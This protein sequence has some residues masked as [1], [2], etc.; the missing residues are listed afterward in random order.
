[1]AYLCSDGARGGSFLRWGRWAGFGWLRYQYQRI[2]SRRHYH[3]LGLDPDLTGLIPDGNSNPGASLVPSLAFIAVGELVASASNAYVG[4]VGPS[5]FGSGGGANASSGSGD[6]IAI[7]GG[8]NGAGDLVV[9]AGHTSGTSVS[10]SDTYTNQTFASLKP[11]P[12]HLYLYVRERMARLIQLAV[13][14]GAVPEP[15]T[16]ILLSLGAGGFAGCRS[17]EGEGFLTMPLRSRCRRV[18]GGGEGAGFSWLLP[19]TLL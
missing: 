2:W 7:Q 3:G 12:K 15:S 16:L 8:G 11:N 5:S 17:A 10:A 1:M 4:I 18:D 6:Q 14:I 9:P 13:I 19:K